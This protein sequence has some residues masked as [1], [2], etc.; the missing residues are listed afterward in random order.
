VVERWLS[1]KTSEG[2]RPDLVGCQNDAMAAGAG[3]A[4]AAFVVR[5]ELAAVRLTGCDGLVDGGRR[6]VDEGRLAATVITPSNTGPAI[7]LVARALAER[8]QPQA[9]LL[10]EPAPYPK[11]D[12]LGPRPQTAIPVSR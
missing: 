5:P 9:E 1:L 11:T 3:K 7:D 10:L 4:L 8:R 2:L 12:A 6:L